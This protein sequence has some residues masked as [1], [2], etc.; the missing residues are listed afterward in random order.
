MGNSELLTLPRPF[1][2]DL[3]DLSDL[4][5]LTMQVCSPQFTW[6]IKTRSYQ[7]QS[8]LVTWPGTPSFFGN[9]SFCFFFIPLA[10]ALKFL[11]PC[12]VIFVLSL[13]QK[14][15]GNRNWWQN[16]LKTNDSCPANFQQLEKQIVCEFPATLKHQTSNWKNLFHRGDGLVFVTR[17]LPLVFPGTCFILLLYPRSKQH[18]ARF[19]GLCASL[20]F[21]VSILVTGYWC[22]DLIRGTVVGWVWNQN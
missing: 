7:I 19:C 5:D 18:E 21:Y 12:I 11:S 14:V 9:G 2:G 10:G 4:I 20:C 1:F 8:C 17:S 16:V 13:C 22:S 6:S 3:T 15:L